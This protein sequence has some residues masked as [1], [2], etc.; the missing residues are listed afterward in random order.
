MV[1]LGANLKILIVDD[2]IEKAKII[3][4]ILKKHL[5]Y[6]SDI[7]S[8]AEEAYQILEPENPNKESEYKIILMD[9]YMPGGQDGIQATRY[10]KSTKK[11]KDIPILIIT[12]DNDEEVIDSCFKAG[13]MDYINTAPIR[14]LELLARVNSAIRLYHELERLKR[15]E[16]ILKLKTK[17]L[18]KKKKILEKISIHD[19]LTNLY[20]RR[21]LDRFLEEEWDKLQN[22]E[23]EL[24]LLMLD[25]DYFKLFNDR[26]GHQEG[27]KA[28]IQVAEVLKKSARRG[29]D[30]VA[31]YGGEEFCI[32][33]PMTK[34]D[35]AIFVAKNIQKDLN[36]LNIPH[37]DS[38][39]KKLTISIGVT[40]YHTDFE[41]Q[42]T[43]ND[44]INQADKALYL[45]KQNGRNKIEVYGN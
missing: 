2:S 37:E 4:R 28:L 11:F 45:A 36:S 35:G 31:R 9:V 30:L 15:R 21:Y 3:Q 12:V 42:I 34:K 14:E 10:L 38:P 44:L 43:V 39:Y 27:D 19:P 20:N 40:H 7:V 32:V 24:S 18:K 16:E 23:G 8:S 41:S 13:A 33:L 22:T 6:P 29:R 17:E 5:P 25:V 1:V 26:Y